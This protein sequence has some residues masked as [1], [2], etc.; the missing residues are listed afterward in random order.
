MRANI[1]AEGKS[2]TVIPKGKHRDEA[3]GVSILVCGIYGIDAGGIHDDQSVDVDSLDWAEPVLSGEWGNIR[4]RKLS[5]PDTPFAIDIQIYENT[6]DIPL[7]II[8][9]LGCCYTLLS[10]YLTQR[11]KEKIIPLFPVSFF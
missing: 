6:S 9:T 4:Y 2:F 1:S 8:I 7:N 10:L 5:N 11:M 3:R